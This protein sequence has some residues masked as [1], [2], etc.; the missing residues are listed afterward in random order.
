MHSKGL[1]GWPCE[2]MDHNGST[3]Q[4]AYSMFGVIVGNGAGYVI[5]SMSRYLG[6]YAQFY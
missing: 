2:A 4:L 5:R 1:A 3:Y 6:S